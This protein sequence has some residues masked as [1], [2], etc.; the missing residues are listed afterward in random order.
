MSNSRETAILHV[1]DDETDQFFLERSLRNAGFNG[2][3]LTT[4]TVDAAKRLLL[5][6]NEFAD[7]KKFPLPGCIICDR[8]IRGENGLDLA[9]WVK[10]HGRYNAIKIC[11][12]TGSDSRTDEAEARSLGF[13]CYRTKPR[14]AEEWNDVAK[15]IL[16][17]C[18]ES[19]PPTS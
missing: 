8:R 13:L 15:F 18:F 2:H 17:Y 5:G 4:D 6:T 14:R 3:F 10:S 1:D 11:I 7:R 9:K 16:D 19:P 12:V